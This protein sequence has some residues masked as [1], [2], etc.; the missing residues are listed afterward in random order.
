M[1]WFC[2]GHLHNITFNFG[3][4]GATEKLW[5]ANTVSFP[6]LCIV[7]CCGITY[8]FPMCQVTEKYTST[9]EKLA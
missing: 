1:L 3:V 5:K 4:D 8:N 9:F 6:N 7:V 2:K